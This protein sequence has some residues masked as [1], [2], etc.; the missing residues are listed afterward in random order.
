VTN[1]F[2][3]LFAALARRRA[4][5]R[6]DRQIALALLQASRGWDNPLP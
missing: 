6:K 1:P 3:L 2:K 5:I 4:K